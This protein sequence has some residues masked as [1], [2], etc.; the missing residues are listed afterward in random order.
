MSIPASFSEPEEKKASFKAFKV[1]R[2]SS[3][4]FAFAT[5]EFLIFVVVKLL[6][7]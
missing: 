1:L 6:K 5:I 7:S 3:S 4:Q 2:I